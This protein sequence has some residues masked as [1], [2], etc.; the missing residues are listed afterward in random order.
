MAIIAF[1]SPKRPSLSAKRLSN[2]DDAALAK[3]KVSLFFGRLALVIVILIT[4]FPIYWMFRTAFSNNRAMFSEPL[5]LLPV[6]FTFGP[7]QRV[8]GL[9]TTEEALAEGGSG[10]SIN[11]GQYM[12][13]S[14]LA[15][16]LITVLQVTF[17][18]M[19]AYAFA[20]LNW[21]GRDK[22]FAIFLIALM[23]P[24]IF[25][26]LPNFILVKDLGLLNT[27][28]GIALP[29][30]FMTPFAIFFLRQF[31]LGVNRSI[32]EAAVI[33][34]A[35]HWRIFS[36]IVVPLAWPQIITLGILQFIQYWNDY[37]WPFLVGQSETSKL[38]TVGLGIFKS[39]T[40]QGNPDWAGLMAGALVAAV[41][42]FILML[43]FGRKIVG[44]IQSSGVK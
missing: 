37:L 11:F 23:V 17:S 43:V 6:D 10:A 4:L 3:S 19:A 40:P 15:C 32:I 42:I 7:L 9:A 5:S 38:L 14:V 30:M 29:A 24:G 41:P 33:D 12:L 28:L 36:R 22:V 35:N 26:L 44:S 25:T 27:I 21:K 31:F 8:L 39:Q 13:N 18:S 34:G 2:A 20:L 16:T 1:K